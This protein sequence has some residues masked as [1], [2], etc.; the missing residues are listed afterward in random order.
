V[1]GVRSDAPHLSEADRA[2]LAAGRYGAAIAI[3]RELHWS[4]R[5][6][7]DAPADLV[8]ELLIRMGAEN[9]ALEQKRKLDGQGR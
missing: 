4:W 2:A 3:M 9:D 8:Q 1:H 6:L 7:R 5:D